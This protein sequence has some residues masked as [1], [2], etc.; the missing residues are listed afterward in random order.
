MPMPIE[1]PPHPL[2]EPQTARTTMRF[3]ERFIVETEIRYTPLGLLA[4]GGMVAAI[5]LA[6]AP[7]VRA[8]AQHRRVLPPA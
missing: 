7:L 3:G 6:S 4:V 5:L 2:A 8:K 1:T